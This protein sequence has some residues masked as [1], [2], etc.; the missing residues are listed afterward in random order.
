MHGNQHL[1][2]DTYASAIGM[3]LGAVVGVLAGWDVFLV[4]FSALAGAGVVENAG[5]AWRWVASQTA[6]APSERVVVSRHTA[7]RPLGCVP[8]RGERE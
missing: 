4:F 3:V 2:P 6:R 1:M 8:R 5:D 7:E